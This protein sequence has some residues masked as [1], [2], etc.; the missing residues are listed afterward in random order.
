ME[1]LTYFNVYAQMR[2]SELVKNWPA[3]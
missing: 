2:D 3:V 1:Q